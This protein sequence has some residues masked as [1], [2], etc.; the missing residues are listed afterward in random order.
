MT[1]TDTTAAS[2]AVRTVNNNTTSFP[3]YHMLASTNVNRGVL[4]HAGFSVSYAERA[5]IFA[6]SIK[7]A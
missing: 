2:A 6:Y 5:Q 1:T 4:G 3:R 7:S